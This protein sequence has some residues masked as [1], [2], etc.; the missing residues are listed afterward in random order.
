MNTSIRRVQARDRRRAAI[1]EASHL[2]IARHFKVPGIGAA[3]WP[4][5]TI[6]PRCSVTWTGQFSIPRGAWNRLSGRRA[7]MIGVAGAL[8]EEVWLERTTGERLGYLEDFFSEPDV[9][10]PTDWNLACAQPGEATSGLI[11]NADRVVDL[12]GQPSVWNAV[13]QGAR[14]LMRVGKL[15]GGD[16]QRSRDD[17]DGWLERRPARDAEASL[18][19]QQIAELLAQPAAERAAR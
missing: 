12:L 4:T 19:Q 9:M 10:S 3:I 1:H 18:L 11:R 13:C 17:F 2:V 15:Y 14:Q 6:D 5:G 8:A 16:D 7:A